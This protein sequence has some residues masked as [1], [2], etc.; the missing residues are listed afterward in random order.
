MDLQ[1]LNDETYL[2]QTFQDNLKLHIAI[3]QTHGFI[4]EKLKKIGLMPA[5]DTL[6]ENLTS[7][8]IKF[9]LDNYELNDIQE[10]QINLFINPEKMSK[11]SKN[12]KLTNSQIVEYL[13]NGKTLPEKTRLSLE[14]ILKYEDKILEQESL[15]E[16]SIEQIL[17]KSFDLFSANDYLKINQSFLEKIPYVL[18]DDASLFENNDYK[19]LY[20]EVLISSDSK[21]DIWDFKHYGF[22][23][24]D[25]E[26]IDLLIK[27]TSSYHLKKYSN[28]EGLAGFSK[29]YDKDSFFKNFYYHVTSLTQYSEKETQDK[30]DFIQEIISKS[31][32]GYRFFKDLLTTDASYSQFIEIVD[33]KLIDM[34]LQTY[35]DRGMLE[36]LDRDSPDETANKY[37]HMQT[38]LLDRIT[39][40]TDLM[41]KVGLY[42]LGNLVRHLTEDDYKF[43]KY[44]NVEA[45]KKQNNHKIEKIF[46]EYIPT[47]FDND[48]F[49]ELMSGKSSIFTKENTK[50]LIKS[51]EK[52][53]NPNALYFLLQENHAGGVYG[54]N[55]HY[56][57]ESIKLIHENILKKDKNVSDEQYLS[58]LKTSL[59]IIDYFIKLSQDDEKDDKGIKNDFLKNLKKDYN[60]FIQKKIKKQKIIKDSQNIFAFEELSLEEISQD[61]YMHIVSVRPEFYDYLLSFKKEL[62]NEFIHFSLRNSSYEPARNFLKFYVLEHRNSIEKDNSL[63]NSFL[64]NDY[65]KEIFPVNDALED[66]RNYELLDK[67]ANRIDK[68]EME[69][70]EIKKRFNLNNDYHYIYSRK[71][72]NLEPIDIQSFDEN[73]THEDYSKNKSKA[74]V[75][76]VDLY[77]KSSSLNK[78]YSD[79]ENKLSHE[80]IEKNLKKALDNKDFSRVKWIYEKRHQHSLKQLFTQYV[81]QSS[82]EQLMK[83]LNDSNFVDILKKQI[84]YHN[85][86]EI[87]FQSFTTAQKIKLSNKLISIFESESDSYYSKPFN[88]FKQEDRDFIKEYVI[89]KMPTNV[90]FGYDFRPTRILKNDSSFITSP[91]TPEDLY[92]TYQNLEKTKGFFSY[93]DVNAHYDGF[94]ATVFGD[95]GFGKKDE[96]TRI[97]KL[98]E[99]KDFL[100]FVEKNDSQLYVLLAHDHCFSGLLEWGNKKNQE[101]HEITTKDEA[102]HHFFLENFNVD[103]MLNGMDII[104]EKMKSSSNSYGEKEKYNNKLASHVITRIGFLTYYDK[105]D[106]NHRRHYYSQMSEK[107]LIKIMK[108][109]FEKSPEHFIEIHRLGTLD[110]EKMPEF[111]FK[112]FDEITTPESIRNFFTPDSRIY[113]EYFNIRD[114]DQMKAKFTKIS[115]IILEKCIEKKDNQM[116]EYIKYLCD[117]EKY[118]DKGLDYNCSQ[119]YQRKYV[120]YHV[121]MTFLSKLNEEENFSSSLSNIMLKIKLDENLQ[122]IPKVNLEKP[123]RK[124]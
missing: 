4:L 24:E 64:S 81:N 38:L 112:H 124:I 7:A 12:I 54:D 73:A 28:L 17:K 61:N 25:K 30:K 45:I 42:E 83:D 49:G 119:K 77:Q 94:F 51:I 121:D 31:L 70:E 99:F 35:K 95:D 65:Q 1:L 88:F 91:Y 79:I 23:H 57:N 5:V 85:K 59:L 103:V 13:E 110:E 93:T 15:E 37:F 39:Q 117:F 8:N 2:R 78:E 90:I 16:N 46:Q 96:K 75:R 76:F 32:K 122:E 89:E 74:K 40:S 36:Y 106:E 47:L 72:L 120:P 56:L 98:K 20:K 87:Q 62:P 14:I 52:G 53:N 107:D 29:I 116:I 50:R 43:N 104:L 58:R 33:E 10:N 22:T 9:I 44:P 80:F 111:F 105:Y 115:Q 69:K 71:D 3:E 97:K 92:R 101:L 26:F 11:K 55:R 66:E 63:M 67:I 84:D 68:I 102:I 108:F 123:K 21:Y 18:R 6:L 113:C 82:Y 114:S 27:K 109:F 19:K 48:N 34:M 86:T 118:M 100:K 41:K 60:F